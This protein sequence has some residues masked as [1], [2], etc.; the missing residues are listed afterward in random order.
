MQ[1]AH[2][3]PAVFPNPDAFDPER[4]LE[5]RYT[6]GEYAPFGVLVPAGPAA[7]VYR[8]AWQRIQDGDVPRFE[9]L[10]VRR[11]RRR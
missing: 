9:E 11:G 5:R 10:K 6:R 7:D 4:F 2:R 3:D 8:A 1:E